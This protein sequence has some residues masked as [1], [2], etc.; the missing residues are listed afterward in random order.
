LR[1]SSNQILRNKMHWIYYQT[2]Y[3]IMLYCENAI[4]VFVYAIYDEL[5]FESQSQ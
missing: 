2:H 3:Q 4:L 5:S 1:I